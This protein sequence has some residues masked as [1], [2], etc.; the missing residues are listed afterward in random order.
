M[1]QNMGLS[2]FSISVFRVCL[3]VALL[4]ILYLAT[5][6]LSHPVMASVNDKFGH[7]L[8]FVTLAFLADFSFPASRFHFQKILLLMAYGIAIEIMQYF[9][10]NRMFSLLDMVADGVG[11]LLYIVMIPFLRQMPFFKLR[12][13]ARKQPS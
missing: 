4:L 6:E 2:P 5:I 13:S 3:G 7:I 12:W 8:A 10:P 1:I 11:I 9:L